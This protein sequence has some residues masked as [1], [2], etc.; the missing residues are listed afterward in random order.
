M[1]KTD[2]ESLAAVDLY[3]GEICD[4]IIRDTGTLTF[5]I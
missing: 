1:K 2:Y 3:T 4:F 5:S